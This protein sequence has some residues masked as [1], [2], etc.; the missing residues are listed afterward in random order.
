M[1]LEEREKRLLARTD[2]LNSGMSE[3]SGTL[4]FQQQDG[5]EEWKLGQIRGWSLSE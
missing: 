2:P 1:E 4:E 5:G 3:Q